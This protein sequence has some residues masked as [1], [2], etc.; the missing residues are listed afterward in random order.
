MTSYDMRYRNVNYAPLELLKN[1]SG[2]PHLDIDLTIWTRVLLGGL[3]CHFSC[4][5]FP[6]CTCHCIRRWNK[7]LGISRSLKRQP[8]DR[9]GDPGGSVRGTNA[10]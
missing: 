3:L 2:S 6:H 8:F 7:A 5:T 4:H 9:T 10:L 1:I